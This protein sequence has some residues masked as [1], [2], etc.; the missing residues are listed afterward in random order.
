MHYVGV[1]AMRMQGSF[2][3]DRAQVAASLLAGGVFGAVSVLAMS[4]LRSVSRQLLL[5]TLLS[6][7]ICLLHFTGMSAMSL[8]LGL[9]RGYQDGLVGSQTLAAVVGSLSVALLL[10]SLSLSIMDRHLSD[11]S[12]RV[13]GE[14]SLRS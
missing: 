11:R 1:S 6:L 9:G 14:T 8:H 13:W 7:A 12:T 2:T 3:L 4:D 5:M 10:I